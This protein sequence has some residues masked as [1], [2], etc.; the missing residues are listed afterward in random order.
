MYHSVTKRKVK[1]LSKLVC[2][3]PNEK[4][5]LRSYNSLCGAIGFALVVQAHPGTR[6]F[7][8]IFSLTEFEQVCNK[9]FGLGGSSLPRDDSHLVFVAAYI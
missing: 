9:S 3:L 4:V 1:C 2:L 8:F 7:Y 5:S 6:I